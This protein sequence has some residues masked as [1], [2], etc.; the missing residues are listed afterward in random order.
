MQK[1][2]SQFT[3]SSHYGKEEKE[4]KTPPRTALAGKDKNAHHKIL[5][6]QNNL[7]TITTTT[8]KTTTTAAGTLQGQISGPL[9]RQDV[10]LSQQKLQ[11][12]L[13]G[14]AKRGG[15][16]FIDT[17]E[18]EEE[19]EED[20]VTIGAI[21]P[22]IISGQIGMIPR[23]QQIEDKEIESIPQKI[24]ELPFTPWI[25]EEMMVEFADSEDEYE[26]ED[27]DE[28]KKE[29]KTF[30]TLQ[31]TSVFLSKH[32]LNE[33]MKAVEAEDLLSLTIPSPPPPPP[34]PPIDLPHN[35]LPSSQQQQQQQPQPQPQKSSLSIHSQRLTRKTFT[36]ALHRESR[37]TTTAVRHA[38]PAAARLTA[39]LPRRVPGYLAPTASAT[40]K[41]RG[42]MTGTR[43]DNNN[44]NNNN[45]NNSN[46]H[47][48]PGQAR[49]L[50]RGVLSIHSMG[51]YAA[52]SSWR[53][54]GNSLRAN[55]E[56]RKALQSM[57]KPEVVINGVET[58]PISNSSN[59]TNSNNGNNRNNEDSN[60]G[61]SEPD[62][63]LDLNLDLDLDLDLSAALD[64]DMLNLLENSPL[65][66]CLSDE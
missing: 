41:Q 46:N 15:L 49:R 8:K 14:S 56:E 64:K 10:H 57:E 4:G 20:T 63:M 34:P 23:L 32:K 6:N 9:R 59:N 47:N 16:V 7:R 11:A 19:E 48:K 61:S 36:T 12:S 26:D 44:N 54:Q 1:K 66:N 53:D 60:N 50:Q 29:N 37:T 52:A 39:T 40:A 27:D 43:L 2:N 30:K 22:T 18:K 5:E 17:E 28:G 35:Q 65:E 42:V 24:P 25:E 51:R 58:M 38:H 21:Q 13:R 62:F 45:N 55:N 31:S 33:M 3:A